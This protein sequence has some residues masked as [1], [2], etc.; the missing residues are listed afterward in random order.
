PDRETLFFS[1]RLLI[2]GLA[3]RQPTVLILEDLHWAD[4]SLLD[5]IEFLAARVRD[6]PLLLLTLARP[7]LRSRR[8]SWGGGL[9]AYTAPALEPLGA[10]DA[11]ELTRRLL[12]QT[13]VD[14]PADQA[15][16]LANTA[17]GNPLV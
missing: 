10:S 13:S 2:E 12:S 7:E 6:V 14:R 9:P 16:A 4:P 1:A 5:L 3:A 11:L 17:E 8:Q 15:E